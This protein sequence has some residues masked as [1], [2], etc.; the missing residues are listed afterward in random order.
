MTTEKSLISAIEDLKFLQLEISNSEFS[1]VAEG[2]KDTQLAQKEAY[3]S[4]WSIVRIRVEQ[5][6]KEKKDFGSDG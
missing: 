6:I 5:L 3:E 4:M 2:L 1:L